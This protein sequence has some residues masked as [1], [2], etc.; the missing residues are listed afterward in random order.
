[1]DFPGG[2]LAIYSLISLWRKL[3][4][5]GMSGGLWGLRISLNW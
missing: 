3:N 4:G 5:L 2:H 1:M